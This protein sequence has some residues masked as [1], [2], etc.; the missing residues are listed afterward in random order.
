MGK[1]CTAEPCRSIAELLVRSIEWSLL[2]GLIG[3]LFRAVSTARLPI[4]S[5][6]RQL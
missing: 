4:T 6:L 2:I 5:A 3:G 1:G